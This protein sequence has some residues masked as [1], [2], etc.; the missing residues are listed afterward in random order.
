MAGYIEILTDHSLTEEQWDRSIFE[1]YVLQSWWSNFMG[2]NESA[3]IQVSDDLSKDAGDALTFGLMG[4]QEGGVVRGNKKGKGNEGRT[5]FYGQRVTIDNVRVLTLIED[6]PMTSKRVGWDVLQKAKR[7][8]ITKARI[9]LEDDITE[10]LT[11]ISTER[12]RGRY[13]YGAADSNWNSTHAT[14]LQN[15]DATNDMLTADMISAAKRKAEIPVNATAPIT[16]MMVKIGKNYEEWFVFVGHTYSIRDLIN[17]DAA[18]KN[19]HLNIP[20]QANSDSPLFTGNAFKGAWDGVLIY[21]YR[22][23]PLIS[24]TIQ[25]S[26]SLLLGAQAAGV[27]WGQR[28][29]FGEQ[30]EDYGHD[31]G[32]ELHEIRGIN[33]FVFD[34]ST[35][36]DHGL[37][38][39]F[40]A[41]VAD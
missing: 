11:T 32:Y 12:V 36:E 25:V 37:V 34:R 2:S 17:K 10:A 20:P 6:V 35:T 4:L 33:K 39:V 3:I 19:V 31:Q 24:S 14:A 21:D 38:N 26:H 29:K 28:S 41:A 16:P 5:K 8:L 27:A 22:R 18:F 15:V 9:T 7:S 1:E 40:P 13:L 23:I 30:K